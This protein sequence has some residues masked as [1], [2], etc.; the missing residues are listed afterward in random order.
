MFDGGR[1]AAF[2]WYDLGECNYEGWRFPLHDDEAYLF[3]AFT[4]A[5]WRG[6]GV[7]PYLRHRVYQ[8]LSGWGRSRFYSVSIRTNKAAIRF[9]EKLGGRVVGK[10][11]VL[12]LFGRWRFGSRPPDRHP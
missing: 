3:D 12:V 8:L 2:T 10:G 1:L 7:A 9:K 6:R 4:L 11:W 5:P